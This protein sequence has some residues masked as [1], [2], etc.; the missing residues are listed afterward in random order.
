MCCEVAG[1]LPSEI[2]EV[3]PNDWQFINHAMNKR[4][5]DERKFW[6]KLFGGT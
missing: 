5:N 4:I 2:G 1:K 3:D 6:I